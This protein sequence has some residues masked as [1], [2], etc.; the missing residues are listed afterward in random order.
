MS[1]PNLPPNVQSLEN[2][3]SFSFDCLTTNSCFTECCRQ[4]ELTLSPYDVLRLRRSTGLSSAE[5]LDKYVIIEQSPEDIFPSCYLTM[6]DDGRAS[7]VFV[8]EKGCTVYENRPGACRTYPMGRGITQKNNGIS[9]IFVLLKEDHCLGFSNRTEQTALSY[10]GSQ[11]LSPYNRFTD[12]LADIIQ[13]EKVR[14]GFSP[15]KQQI[16]L[17]LLALYNIDLFRKK[18]LAGEIEPLPGTTKKSVEA[19]D[20]EELLLYSMNWIKI[21]FFDN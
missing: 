7:C 6:V 12:L 10:I 1:Q 3:E 8:S 18:L 2:G 11:G 5:F 15:N 21:S 17:F 16:E 4:L 13:H 19:L 14:Q 9:E 20:D